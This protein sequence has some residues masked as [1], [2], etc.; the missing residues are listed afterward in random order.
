MN[1]TYLCY[2]G[3]KVDY[4]MTVGKGFRLMDVSFDKRQ[5]YKKAEQFAPP[6]PQILP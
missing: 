6:F 1:L 4:H 3:S 2:G 5:E